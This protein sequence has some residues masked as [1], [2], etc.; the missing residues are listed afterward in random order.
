MIKVDDQEYRNRK[1]IS[2]E[3]KQANINMDGHSFSN[4]S[5]IGNDHNSTV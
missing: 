4:N 3:I 1:T 5:I 2:I